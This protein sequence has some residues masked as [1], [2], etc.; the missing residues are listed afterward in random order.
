[1]KFN[2]RFVLL[3]EG[4]VFKAYKIKITFTH[5]IVVRRSEVKFS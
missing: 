1:M 3:M 2:D 5:G 4:F